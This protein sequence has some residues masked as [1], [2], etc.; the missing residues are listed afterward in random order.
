MQFASLRRLGAWLS[1]NSRR[2]KEP[3]PTKGDRLVEIPIYPWPTWETVG[4]VREALYGLQLG[5]IKPAA[6]LWDEM[7]TDDRFHSA[8]RKRQTNLLGLPMDF[9]P[10][11]PTPLAKRMAEELKLRW[12]QMFP[13]NSLSQLLDWGNGI[14]VGFGQ[15]V[16]ERSGGEWIQ[17]ARVWHPSNS[18][19][20][21]LT[22]RFVL[23]TQNEGM[24][25]L[26]PED[27]EWLIYTPYGADNKFW[28]EALIRSTAVLWLLRK[29][30]QRDWARFSEVHGLPIKK[31]TIPANAEPDEKND[32]FTSLKSLSSEGLIKLPMGPD[33]K[34]LY[35]LELL[36]ARSESWEGI[37]K[38][39]EDTDKCIDIAVLGQN[40]TTDIG[41]KGSFGAA[42]QHQH[43]E[44]GVT[45]FDGQCL[46]TFL[47]NGPVA[48]WAGWYY[49]GGEDHAPWPT[50]QV[51][52][53][54]DLE[55]KAGVFLD[56]SNAAVNFST[57]GV[58]LDWQEISDLFGLPLRGDGMLPAGEP[59]GAGGG[60]N[61]DE[62]QPTDDPAGPEDP[63]IE[64]DGSEQL[65]ARPKPR[66]T[67]SRHVE[68]QL[69]ADALGD[70]AQRAGGRALST[71]VQLV[72]RAVL[73]ARDGEDLRRRLK[74]A[75]SSMDGERFQVLM[76]RALIMAA[77]AGRLSAKRK[78]G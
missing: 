28:R 58:A 34:P 64:G 43:T 36:E 15:L 67:G 61:P 75:F 49:P 45:K 77:A 13:E 5:R 39:K 10:A 17:R 46:S 68:G 57:A 59:G 4:S 25:E 29:W 47:R 14:G 23:I 24:I 53:P 73:N 40:L 1:G 19:Y 6:L 44:A 54:E 62:G 74:R 8:L 2:F 33:G 52:E 71:D 26:D 70:E 63:G 30:A 22:R 42:K 16:W 65:S 48:W 11:D 76:Q 69:Y 18:Y 7:R 21:F 32:F 56:L 72:K 51:E 31:A 27:P 41:A 12:W 78:D 3:P 9:Q 60:E 35:N 55:K 20:N 37:Q 50:W 66:A 38:L